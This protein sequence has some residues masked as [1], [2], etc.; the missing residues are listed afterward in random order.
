MLYPFG[1]LYGGLVALIRSLY[2]LG[3]FRVWRF[4]NLLIIKVGNLSVGGTGKTPHTAFLLRY[5]EK[6]SKKLAVVSR[7]YGRMS[8]HNKIVEL[9][10]LPD[11]SG[12]EPLMLKHQFPNTTVVVARRRAEGLQLLQKTTPYIYG[13]LLDDAMQ[14]WAVQSDLDIL[15]TTFAKPFFADFPLPAGRLREF[16]TNFIRANVIV[17]TQ[18]PPILLQ[19]DE[20]FFRKRIN[21][22]KNQILLFSYYNYEQPYSLADV[23]DV[24]GWQALANSRTLV[25][26]AIAQTDYIEQFLSTHTAQS[27]IFSFLD[28]HLFTQA[29]IYLMIEEFK[30]TDFDCILT[31]EKDA[32][33]LRPFLSDFQREAIPVFVLPIVVQ[34]HNNGEE[35][36]DQFLS[37]YLEKLPN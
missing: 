5:F 2:K 18:C 13:V 4:P 16:R 24:L 19:K 11:Q 31:T 17:V 33:R 22:Q 21:L 28:H 12:D 3:F 25:V 34:F 9:S 26:L 1:I 37:P 15:L 29:D 7:G 35:V 27:K 6:K 32:V 8:K 36:L 30:K 10:D 23:G 20:E 14:H